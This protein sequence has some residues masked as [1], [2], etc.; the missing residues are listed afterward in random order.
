MGIQELVATKFHQIGKEE[1]K[2][3]G[4][5]EGMAKGLKTSRLV[6]NALQSGTLPQDIASQYDLPLQEVLE[7]KATFGL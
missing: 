2:A 5:A 3:E 1:G 6:F 4:K 7:L